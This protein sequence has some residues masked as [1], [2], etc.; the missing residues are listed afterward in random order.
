VLAIPVFLAGVAVSVDE[1]HFPLEARDVAPAVGGVPRAGQQ[2]G[3]SQE[4]H[5]TDHDP[6]EEQ[7]CR[8]TP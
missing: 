4:A 8:S 1:R 5:R 3:K 2:R 7:N 6:K